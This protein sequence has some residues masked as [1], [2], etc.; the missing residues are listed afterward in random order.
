MTQQEFLDRYNQTGTV[1]EAL[2]KSIGAAVQHNKLY[3]NVGH[4]ER[5][6]IRDYWRELL[7]QL[8]NQFLAENWNEEYYEEK[9]LE[10][11]AN[12]NNQFE[13]MVDFRISHSQKSL[14]VFFKHRW[15]LGDFPIPPQCPVDRIILT[16][17]NAPRNERSWGFINDIETHRSRYQII[18]QASIAD[19]FDN[20]SIWELENF[21]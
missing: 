13:E 4:N 6:E 7:L 9:I 19:G 11:K 12:M 16:R 18:R 2:S 5:L 17:A 1:E 20:V 8:S 21:E 10:L 3:N 15:C 14:S